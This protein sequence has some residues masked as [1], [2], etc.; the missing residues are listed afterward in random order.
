MNFQSG[1]KRRFFSCFASPF[2]CIFKSRADEDAWSILTHVKVEYCMN[3][4]FLQ[5]SQWHT[6]HTTA[7]LC[8]VTGTQL[9][10]TIRSLYVNITKIDIPYY[11]SMLL[12]HQTYKIVEYINV[13]C[14]VFFHFFVLKSRYFFACSLFLK[15]AINN[16]FRLQLDLL[17]S[18]RISFSCLFW[19]GAAKRRSDCNKLFCLFWFRAALSWRAYILLTFKGTGLL[20]AIF[21]LNHSSFIPD[22]LFCLCWFRAAFS[23]RA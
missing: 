4:S 1:F 5:W 20:K 22:A 12:I 3:D 8:S 14:L 10:L 9:Q 21:V 7:L 11:F 23:W 2:S 15:L 13:V 18:A 19:Y 16:R 6:Y 17:Y